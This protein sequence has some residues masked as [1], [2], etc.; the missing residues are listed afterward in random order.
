MSFTPKYS[1]NVQT[2]EFIRLLGVLSITARQKNDGEFLNFI[3][4][5]TT[6]GELGEEPGERD[7]LAGLS[8][9]GSVTG[10]LA[11][12]CVGQ[13][14][15]PLL[16]TTASAKTLIGTFSSVISDLEEKDEHFVSIVVLEDVDDLSLTIQ[17]RTYDVTGADDTDPTELRVK[18]LSTGSYNGGGFGALVSGRSSAVVMTEDGPLD[19]GQLTQLSGD[20]LA[21]LGKVSKKMKNPVVK[22][23]RKGHGASNFQ[24]EIG[25]WIGSILPVKW[26]IDTDVNDLFGDVHLPEPASTLVSTN[27]DED[28][29][30]Q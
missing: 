27:D 19:D 17:V 11:V 29:D 24:L 16:I 21:T 26:G 22:M 30:D 1:I 4:L 10:S 7:I 20:D 25:A 14:A 15:E 23:F 8:S 12:E 2:T 6:R 9:D 18:A 13:M 5:G 28:D 3:E